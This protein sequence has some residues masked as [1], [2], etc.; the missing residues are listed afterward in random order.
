[1]KNKFSIEIDGQHYGLL[2]VKDWAETLEVK[3]KELVDKMINWDAKKWALFACEGFDPYEIDDIDLL[4]D[5]IGT[6]EIRFN[7]KYI[8]ILTSEEEEK[9]LD[10]RLDSWIAFDL[11]IPDW[12][13]PYFDE[14]AWK[15]DQEAY[16][17][18]G[19]YEN[20]RIKFEEAEESEWINIYER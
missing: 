6:E 17:W 12:I 8:Q 14:E 19:D 18:L 5:D 10:E 9:V 7:G 20:F 4:D 1:M 11:D 16:D 13:R 2:D 3:P 15:K